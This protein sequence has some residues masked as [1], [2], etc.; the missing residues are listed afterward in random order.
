MRQLVLRRLEAG[1][2]RPGPDVR[3]PAAG[4]GDGWPEGGPGQGGQRLRRRGLS[5][6]LVRSR[7]QQI[8][9]SFIGRRLQRGQFVTFEARLPRVDSPGDLFRHQLARHDEI[10]QPR[11]LD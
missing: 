9:V 11:P 5:V 6:E 2:V 7:R 8:V 10:P 4:R 1:G 3:P